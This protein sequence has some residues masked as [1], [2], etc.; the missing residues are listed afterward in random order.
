MQGS[1]LKKISLQG[2]NANSKSTKI[3]IQKIRY[4][5]KISG[6]KFLVRKTAGNGSRIFSFG[7]APLKPQEIG[8]K[9]PRPSAPKISKHTIFRSARLLS[10]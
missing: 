7:F 1:M 6:S 5:G 3:L 9:A 10:R 8:F 2:C 4:S